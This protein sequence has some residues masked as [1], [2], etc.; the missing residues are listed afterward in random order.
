M[1][2]F[3][4]GRRFVREKR[5]SGIF[6]QFLVFQFELQMLQPGKQDRTSFHLVS[7]ICV[8]DGNECRSLEHITVSLLEL[9]SGRLTF[10]EDVKIMV[11][12]F[13]KFL[14]HT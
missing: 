11:S 4:V 14:L 7:N 3:L 13:F 8:T 10:T 12:R 9:I 5:P 2:L 1:H 6:N